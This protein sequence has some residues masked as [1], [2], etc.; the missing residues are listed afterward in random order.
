MKGSAS[1]THPIFYYIC[2][3]TFTYYKKHDTE[4]IDRN[5]K[6]PITQ[7]SLQE[8]FAVRVCVFALSCI[9]FWGDL[10]ALMHQQKYT[11]RFPFPK[12]K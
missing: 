1:P 8:E 7:A 4:A 9:L 12:Y 11:V 6:H 3:Y 5:T 10:S 2:I